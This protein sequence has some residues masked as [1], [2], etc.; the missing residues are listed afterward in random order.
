MFYTGTSLKK[1]RS[2]RRSVSLGFLRKSYHHAARRLQE[3][4]TTE[5]QKGG[6]QIIRI[7]KEREG[8]NV[9]GLKLLSRKGIATAA[10][11]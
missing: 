3:E 10:C 6:Y 8:S 4:R 9:G 7:D 2:T 5:I 1:H 11:V